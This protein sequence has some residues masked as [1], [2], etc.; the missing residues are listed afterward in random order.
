[1]MFAD[2]YQPGFDRAVQGAP[3]NVQINAYFRLADNHGLV[4]NVEAD[5]VFQ[6]PMVAGNR[7]NVIAKH[8][9]RF[10]ICRQ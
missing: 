2:M 7:G 4:G 10:Q 8:H 3:F 1:M 5:A 9:I 6:H